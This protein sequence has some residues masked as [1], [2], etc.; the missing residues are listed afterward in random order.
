MKFV[1]FLLLLCLQGCKLLQLVAHIAE[2]SEPPKTCKERSGEQRKQC[3]A[4]VETIKKSIG[5]SQSK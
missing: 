2:H 4:Q 5:K 3:E 1:I